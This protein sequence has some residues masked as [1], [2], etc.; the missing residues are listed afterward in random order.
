MALPLVPVMIGLLGSAF[1]GLAYVAVRAAT[2]TVGVNAIIF[3][4]TATA[5][6]I[7]APLA[8]RQYSVLNVHQF[9]QL[10]IMGIFASIGQFAMTQA[11][12]YA[13]AGLVSTMSLMNA[14][15]SASLGWLLLGE[16]LVP[17]Q[18]AGMVL[19]GASVALIALKGQGRLGSEHAV[20][21]PKV[22]HPASK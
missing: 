15:F 2:A 17:I 19:V 9:S 7:S 4:F 3:Y 12:R 13:A 8:F 14:V 21:D 5:S 20:R 10:I 16:V 1:A 6:L 22:V 11:Y 18:W